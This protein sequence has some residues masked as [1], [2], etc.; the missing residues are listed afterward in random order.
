MPF[1]KRES[2]RINLHIPLAAK[3]KIIGI[4]NK[5]AD[6]KYTKI[7]IKDISAGGIRMHTP[8]DLPV[9]MNLLLEFTFQLFSQ[10]M[11]VLGII[12]RKNILHRTL[13]EYGIKFSI[14]D[15]TLEQLLTGQLQLLSTRLRHTNI[16]TSC[17]FC[18]EEELA[19]IY[20]DYPLT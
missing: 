8:L 5:S 19:E 3:F 14:A 9:N 12:T 18:S 6:T 11:K 7:S 10:D 1:N 16:L 2:F 15:L 20:S 4:D 17:S 13:Y